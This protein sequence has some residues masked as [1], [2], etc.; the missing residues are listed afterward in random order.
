LTEYFFEK[1][2]G[3]G[4][5]FIVFDGRHALPQ[6]STASVAALCH[7]RFGIGADGLM[8]L[9]AAELMDDF[10]LDYY[11]A[12]GGLGSLCGNGSR[13]AVA[14]AKSKQFFQTNRCK[15][16]ASDGLHVA[17]ITENC[18]SVSFQDVKQIQHF[19]EAYMLN[20]GSPH[21]VTFVNALEHVDVFEKGRRIRNTS[22]FIAE[23]IN[24]NFIEEDNMGI[25]NI[26]TYERGVEDE[27]YACGTGAVA[28]AIVQ[29]IS[30]KWFGFQ[31][32]TLQAKGGKLTVAF[33]LDESLQKATNITLTGPAV[34]VFEGTISV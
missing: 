3:A 24:V 9:K 19:Q 13:C 7:R 12:D 14:F 6:L 31:E 11:N 15:F 16:L 30:K 21:Y 1:W 20:T 26:R 34:K 25:L 8:V 10:E 18:V 32:I 27:T 17:S 29:A 22:E 4:N 28:A 2:Q 23:G 33:T 5:D